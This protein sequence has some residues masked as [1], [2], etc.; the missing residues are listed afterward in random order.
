[1][2]TKKS[3]KCQDLTPPVVW[4]PWC[5]MAAVSEIILLSL[6]IRISSP[7]Y[8]PSCGITNSGRISL[9]KTSRTTQH[10]IPLKQSCMNHG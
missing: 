9:W 5:E 8:T 4:C 6:M 7:T 1:M 10:T 3:R 2:F